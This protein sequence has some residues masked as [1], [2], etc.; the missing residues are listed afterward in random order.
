MS[1]KKTVLI[2]GCSVDGIGWALAKEFHSQGFRVFATSRHLETMEDL[3]AIGIETL[4]LDVTAADAIRKTKEEISTRTG[5]KLDILINNAQ[6]I[7]KDSA[8]SDLDI[9]AVR[10]VYETNLFGPIC[11][12]QHF[13]PLL[14]ACNG[15]VVNNGSVAEIVSFPFTSA[16]NSSKAAL[17]SFSDTLRI[18]LAP[19]NV[20]VVHLMTAAVKSNILKPYTFPEDSLYKSME[21]PHRT[22]YVEQEKGAMPTA[23]F[24]RIVVAEITKAA[25]RRSLWAGANA[26]L[27]WVISTFLPK[28]VMVSTTKLSSPLVN[29]PRNIIG[30]GSGG[31]H[32]CEINGPAR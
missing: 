28:S 4:A 17:H 19:F 26:M 9:S 30:L 22:R 3:A 6:P 13:L 8:V 1:E 10:D 29:P 18:E 23:Q 5:G 27:V 2:T 24:A 20:R 14:I 32:R 12:V 15:C 21:E 16:Y 7:G 11:M 25:P 31:C